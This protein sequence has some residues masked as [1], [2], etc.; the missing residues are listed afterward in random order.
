MKL[1]LSSAAAPDL[2]LTGLAEAAVRRGFASLELVEGDAHGLAAGDLSGA[3]ATAA[4]LLERGL[5]PAGWRAERRGAAELAALAPFASA[6]GAPVLAPAPHLPPGA[7]AELLERFEG[8][9]TALRF[10]VRSPEEARGVLDSTGGAA[11]LAWEVAPSGNAIPDPAAML[12]AC[13]SRLAYVIL[14]GG[15]PEAMAQEGRGI[16]A[17]FTALTL[18]RYL[19]PLSLRPSTSS[20]HLAWS[21]WLGRRGGWGCGSKVAASPPVNLPLAEMT[22]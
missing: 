15:G 18:G 16:G 1:T 19:G 5:T 11:F 14:H 3:A 20:Y 8:V 12:A 7:W 10:V 22:R 4:A 17:L 21:T 2:D 13:G 6:L 9:E